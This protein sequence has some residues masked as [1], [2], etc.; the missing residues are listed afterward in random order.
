MSMNRFRLTMTTRERNARRAAARSSV[1]NEAPSP[2]ITESPPT[3][4][5]ALNSDF[6]D[7]ITI[8]DSD[9]DISVN[10]PLADN[11]SPM[12]SDEPVPN[13]RS[14]GD[15]NVELPEINMPDRLPDDQLPPVIT[16]VTDIRQKMVELDE[17]TDKLKDNDSAIR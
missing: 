6:P 11:Q 5:A 3:I 7:I 1:S 8:E 2:S 16:W 15:D 13:S 12:P 17:I 14:D 9:D 4:P 10:V